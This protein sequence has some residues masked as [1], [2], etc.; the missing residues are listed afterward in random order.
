MKKT[1]SLYWPLAIVLPLAAAAFLNLCS[2]AA[3]H[4]S[5]APLAASEVTAELARTVS[6]GFVGDDEAASAQPMRANV[7]LQSQPL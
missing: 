5:T 1:I 4:A 6:Y 2:S 7:T 3:K